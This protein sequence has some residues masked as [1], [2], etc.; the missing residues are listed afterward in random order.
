MLR[1]LA[2]SAD[3][4]TI[5][6]A[7]CQDAV[8]RVGDIH[9]EPRAKRFVMILLRYQWEANG[10]R[11]RIRSVLR[12]EHVDAVKQRKVSGDVLALLSVTATQP[13]LDA[14]NPAAEIILT[15][16]GEAALKISSDSLDIILEDVTDSWQVSHI[17][18]HPA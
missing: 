5:I 10:T 1:L 2:H 18:A 12:I 4:I 17:P 9:F 16:S 8:V 11:R 6:S 13:A 7:L 15:F 14:E 3:D